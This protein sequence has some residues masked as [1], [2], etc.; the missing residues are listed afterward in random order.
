M[1]QIY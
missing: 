1:P